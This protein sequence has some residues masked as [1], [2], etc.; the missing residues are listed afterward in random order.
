[1]SIDAWKCHFLFGFLR[2]DGDFLYGVSMRGR[3]DGMAFWV[4]HNR[5]PA[6]R[7][8]FLSSRQAYAYDVRLVS[9]MIR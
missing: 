8:R 3:A 9:E 6:R 7:R 1:M 2:L 4:M 5:C